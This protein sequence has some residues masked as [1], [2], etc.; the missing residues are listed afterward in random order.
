[1]KEWFIITG[2]SSGIGRELA[3]Q[4]ANAHHNV[5]IT[6]RREIELKRTQVLSK[7]PSLISYVAADF[8]DKSCIGNIVQKLSQTDRVLCLVH[9]AATCEPLAPLLNT[10]EEQFEES[11]RV[12]VTSPLALT[13]KLQPFFVPKARVLFFGSDYVGMDGK[14][15]KDLTGVYGMAKSS[16][17]YAV[18]QLKLEHKEFIVGYINP[19]ATDTDMFK[20]IVTKAGLFNN[21]PKPA[22]TEQVALFVINV[23]KYTDDHEFS[24]IHWDFRKQE[25]Q[26]L[27][28]AY[29][30]ARGFLKVSSKL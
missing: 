13:R 30:Q 18:L 21:T 19:G 17:A 7:N 10:T 11:N 25:Q 2:A 3:I 5:L 23:L 27:F 9:C 22:S 28:S 8:T 29:N 26:E 1:M 12:N 15:R 16:L 20:T 14:M 4:L 6:G 24:K